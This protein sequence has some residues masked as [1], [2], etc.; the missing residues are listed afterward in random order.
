MKKTAARAVLGAS[1]SYFYYLESVLIFLFLSGN[2][3]IIFSQKSDWV[4]QPC[5]DSGNVWMSSEG[6]R[7]FFFFFLLACLFFLFC[8]WALSV[9][10]RP[11]GYRMRRH[12]WNR[13]VDAG[14]SPRLWLQ[15]SVS[16]PLCSLGRTSR[17]V[18][19]TGFTALYT[20]ATYWLQHIY[21]PLH[22]V[23]T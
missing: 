14:S 23:L 8:F 11:R 18:R 17:G 7:L 16:G 13:A 9:H 21:V 5:A 3:W 19:D 12:V 4:W 10:S 15:H 22:S 6:S 1:S 2:I 20:Y